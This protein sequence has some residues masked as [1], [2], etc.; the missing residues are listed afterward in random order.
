MYNLHFS[1][2]VCL[3]LSGFFTVSQAGAQQTVGLFQYD[4]GTADGYTLFGALNHTRIY[5]IDNCGREVHNWT[6]SYLPGATAYLREDGS[7]LRAGRISNSHF[8]TGGLGGHVELLDWDG[9]VTWY[10]DVSDSLHA[11]HHDAFPMPNGNVLLIAW[12]AID[13]ATAVANGRNPGTL[14]SKLW[15]DKLLEIQPTTPGN[16]NIVWEW[17]AW[18]HLIQDWDSTKLNFGTVADHPERIH[19]NYYDPSSEVN[20]LHTNGVSYNAELDQIALSIHRFDEI[21]VIDHSTTTVEAAGHSGGNRGKGGDLLYRWGNPQTYGRGT[22]NDQ[23]FWGQHHVGWVP[24][25]DQYAGMFKVFNNGLG[26]PAGPFSTA[27]I[28]QP[29]VDSLGNYTLLPGQPFGPSS[30][31]WSYADSPAFY[32]NIVS[33][34]QR[35]PGSHTLLCE[36]TTGHFFEIDSLGS[37]VWSYVSP[38]QATGPINQGDSITGNTVFRAHKYPV[39]YPGFA[40]H[41]LSPGDPLE[42]NPLPLP[43]TCQGTATVTTQPPSAVQIAPNPFQDFLEIRLGDGPKRRVEVL[44]LNGRVLHASMASGEPYTLHTSGWPS[45]LY[46]VRIQGSPAAIKVV[47]P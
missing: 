42:G 4:A 10:Y 17:H 13:S 7:L 19:L 40:G 15:A 36:G 18:D 37:T 28:W 5:L 11:Q 43:S 44:D 46:C 32:S 29:P 14:G 22:A 35:L 2:L 20:W 25:G 45:G 12:E 21:W 47:K 23:R 27:D 24:A 26:K 8:A 38:V 9:N 33:G 6:S 16:G 34:M 30:L 39:D 3:L 41:A 1:R 31:A